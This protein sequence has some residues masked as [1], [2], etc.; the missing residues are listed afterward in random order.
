M[1]DEKPTVQPEGLSG[2]DLARAALEEARALA[3][4]QGKPVGMGRSAP[5]RS[6]RRTSDRSRRRWSGAGPDPRDP[7]PLG[8]MVGRVAKQHGWESRISEG[9]LFGM[10]PSIVGDDIASHADPTRLEG[11][12]LHVRAESTAW[13][14]QLRYMQGQIIAKIAKVIGH[15]MVTSLRITGPQAP[16][17]RK[18][19]RHI[20]GRGPRDTYG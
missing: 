6:R 14:T 9:A 7:Q 5:I 11:T 8:S 4:A 16:S 19:P 1:T 12:V 15:G 18:G 2:Y 3:R 20:S 13:A 10:W 17:W